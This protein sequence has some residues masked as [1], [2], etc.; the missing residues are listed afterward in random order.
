MMDPGQDGRGGGGLSRLLMATRRLRRR[1]AAGLAA[2]LGLFALAFAARLTLGALGLKAPLPFATFAPVVLIAPLV[3]GLPAGLMV[4]ILSGLSAWFLFL[5]ANPLPS[6]GSNLVV[7]TTY[8]VSSLMILW[9]MHVLDDEFERLIAERERSE[10]LFREL[11]HRVANN[12]QTVSTIL[13]LQER[14]VV[15]AD[16][17]RGALRDAGGR[18]AAIGALHRRLY[19]PANQTVMLDKNLQGLVA[20]ILASSGR[21]GVAGRIDVEASAILPP[22]RALTL[23]L[24]VNEAVVNALKYAFPDGARGEIRVSLASDGA[25]YLLQVADDG[26]GLAGAAP[27]GESLGARVVASLS[28]QL[29]GTPEW[30]SDG[31]TTFS[32]RFPRA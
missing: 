26:V 11:Q 28:G 3:G 8:V 24:I 31:G 25:D 10:S 29:G 22:E 16:T 20:D 27:D 1:P 5:P 15:D 32:L 18:L 4:V 23:S 6:D 17:G 30:L 13:R 12:L 9:V 19:D 2:A 21:D 7:L 14:D